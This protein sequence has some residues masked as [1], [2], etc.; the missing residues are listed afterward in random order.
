M[1]GRL[2]IGAAVLLASFASA[3]A[4][5]GPAPPVSPTTASSPNAAPAPTAEPDPPLAALIGDRGGLPD[6]DPIDLAARYGITDGTVAASKPFPGEREVGY[7]RDFNLLYITPAALAQ[8]VPPALP[9]ISATLRAKTAHAYFYA[10]S[11]LDISDASLAQAAEAFENTTWPR[12]TGV[13]GEP[14]S[15][16]IDGDP[17]IIVLVADL[18]GAVGGYV[19]SDDAFPRE[20]RPLSNEAEVIYLDDELGVATPSFDAVAAH[21]F[22]HLIHKRNDRSEEAWVN[23]GLSE[24][25][26]GSVAG[27]ISTISAFEA[28]PATQLNRWESTGSS[29]HYGASA[30]F[31]TYVAAR[32]GGDQQAGAI[33]READDGIN[34]VED[35]LSSV[36]GGLSFRDVFADWLAAN[37]L[38]RAAGPYSNGPRPIDPS[39][40]STIAPGEA[41]DAEATQFGADY[42]R[43]DAAPGEHV[44]RFS[45]APSVD[46]LPLA[47]DADGYYWS[48]AGDS[49]DTRL[50]SSEI[51]LT[52][53]ASAALTF[54]IWHDIER[55][56]DWGYVAASADNG[57][58][59][60]ALAGAQTT[61]DDAVRIALGDGYTGTS[62]GGAEPQWVDERID[63][64]AFAGQ[65]ILLRF[66]Y[67]TD[68][69]T[70]GEGWAIDDISFEGVAS[71]PRWDDSEGWVLVDE[72][73][74]QSYVVRVIA[75]RADGEA[76]V[77][78]LPLDA[79]RAGELR[80]D[81]AALADVVIAVAGTT[82]GTN[83]VA[84]YTLSL[85]P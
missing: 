67:V 57:R 29:A 71:P 17:R 4:E 54:R 43:L 64:S 74:P 6:L 1:H 41:V 45:G 85:D 36:A 75:E 11:S 61:A 14:P 65:R 70:H 78:D 42:Y 80:F 52:G 13:F 31:F 24:L 63:L 8:S 48:N 39:I 82:E 5:D 19:L 9:T 81:T 26:F 32:F 56:Y 50:T 30:A 66:E 20:V 49:I 10:D 76:V 44:L 55:W 37:I 51:D 27:T 23:E 47:P 58:T 16:G 38:N 77:L 35:Y 59:W 28:L 84:P 3:C 60:Q 68:G 33:A 34:G 73:L 12:I 22:Q 15:P 7:V 40:E 72:A 25:A 79:A 18:G 62:G 83:Q 46:V 21:E 53:V 2:L 69:S